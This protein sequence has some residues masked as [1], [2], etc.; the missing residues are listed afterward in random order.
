[1][2]MCMLQLFL[3]PQREG[4]A[5]VEVDGET[6]DEALSRINANID[7][8]PQLNSFSCGDISSLLFPGA[9]LCTHRSSP[10]R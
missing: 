10:S 7:S 8:L 4:V 3:W 1:M 6:L 5:D 2:F 9:D